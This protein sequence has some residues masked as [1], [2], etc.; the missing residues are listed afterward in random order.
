[1]LV[2]NMKTGFEPSKIKRLFGGIALSILCGL[3]GILLGCSEKPFQDHLRSSDWIKG[4]ESSFLQLNDKATS[5]QLAILRWI[6]DAPIFSFDAGLE[7]ENIPEACQ[8]RQFQALHSAQQQ[9][10]ALQQVTADYLQKC[11]TQIATGP[12]DMWRNLYRTLFIR[13]GIENNPYL[14]RIVLNLPNGYKQPGLIALKDDQYRRPWI[15]LRAGVLG[16]SVDLQAERFILMQMFEQ[17]PFNMLFLDSMTSAETI[18]LNQRLSVGGLDEGLQNYQIAQKL[19]D[20][21]EPLNRLVSDVHLMAVS[22]GGH[23]LFMAMILNETNPPVFKSAVGLCPMV[24]FRKTF[25]DHEASLWSFFPMNI[26]ASWRMAPL[27]DKIPNIRRTWFLPDAF[28]YVQDNFR[29]PITDQG[30]IQFPPN[31]PKDDFVRGN[32]LLPWI[33][34]I[35]HPVRIFSTLKDNLVPYVFNTGILRELPEKNESIQIYTL[36]EGY[37]CSF[38]GAYSWSEMSAVLKAQ[39]LSDNE[40]ALPPGFRQMDWPLPQLAVGQKVVDHLKFELNEGDELLKVKI[41]TGGSAE[42]HVMIPI[43]ALSW[44]TLPKV[45][46]ETEARV[47]LRF[48]QQNIRLG[49]AQDGRLKLIWAVPPGFTWN[50]DGPAIQ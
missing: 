47:L 23:G 11:E 6:Y 28:K 31:F 46:S 30:K 44:G 15:I 50:P 48:A 25:L 34:L 13:F 38:P 43:G 4:F 45:R 21:A 8:F 24:Q 42:V 36:K 3:L 49:A 41:S 37:H 16:N 5:Q 20:P 7:V 17:G 33:K 12:K 9:G 1:M 39:F 29:G 2:R 22:M 14:R 40:N 27:M 18:R 32:E 35:R 10:K 19:K 26:Y